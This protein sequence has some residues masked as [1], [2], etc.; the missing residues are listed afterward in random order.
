MAT[1]LLRMVIHG[2]EWL[3]MGLYIY[4]IYIYIY[5]YNIYNNT[6]IYIQ[7]I[8]PLEIKGGHVKSLINGGERRFCSV[9]QSNQI[10]RVPLPHL[11]TG[12][13]SYDGHTSTTYRIPH[14]A[15]PRSFA[16]ACVLFDPRI[17]QIC[18]SS[19]KLWEDTEID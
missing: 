11:I 14:N 13:Y 18:V 8:Y 3:I 1:M 4:D 19:D 6:Y 12:V 10:S 16:F 9:K 17:Q 7:E 5:I 15:S 2:Y